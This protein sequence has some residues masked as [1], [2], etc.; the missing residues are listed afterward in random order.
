MCAFTLFLFLTNF[1]KHA[2]FLG[3]PS[4]IHPSC[5]SPWHSSSLCPHLFNHWCLFPHSKYS[6]PMSKDNFSRTNILFWMATITFHVQI[7]F[8]WC[9]GSLILDAHSL[10]QLNVCM[11]TRSGHQKEQ[12]YPSYLL[13]VK[14]HRISKLLAVEMNRNTARSFA[15]FRALEG[16]SRASGAKQA[17]YHWAASSEWEAVL[18]EEHREE[19]VVDSMLIF[20]FFLEATLNLSNHSNKQHQLL[21][22]RTS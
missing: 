13:K 9:S 12:R 21:S 5:A 14:V 4:G 7:F 15:Y 8:L 19:E 6:K 20:S 2:W 1:S 11:S 3:P 18:E 10:T 16:G 22:S 17:L